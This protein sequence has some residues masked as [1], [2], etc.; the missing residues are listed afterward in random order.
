MK[1]F[2]FDFDG[3]ICNSKKIAFDIHNQ[4]SLKYHIPLIKNSNDYL[5]IIDDGVINQYLTLE[6]KSNYY[7]DNNK[8]IYDISNKLKIY[9]YMKLL[10]KKNFENIFI[11]SS[12]TEEIINLILSNNDIKNNIVV[13]GKESEK[14]KALRIE[15]LLRQKKLQ[16]DDI[17]Y[18]GDTVDDLKFCQ[19]TG[20]KMIGSN[21]GYSNLK[22]Y[23]EELLELFYSDKELFEYIE[24]NWAR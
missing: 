5:N 21:Y 14:T 6:N 9:P 11:V 22:S 17:I 18:I 16:K 19:K 23:K 24:K 2:V 8:L 7:E 12:N 3:V 20:I 1:S 15:L 4:L 13:I 10:L